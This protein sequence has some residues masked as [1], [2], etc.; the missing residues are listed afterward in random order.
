MPNY[1]LYINH[2][3]KI[4]CLETKINWS[5][6]GKPVALYTVGGTFLFIIKFLPYE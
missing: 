6:F 1:K 5:K 4:L 3:N 2:Q